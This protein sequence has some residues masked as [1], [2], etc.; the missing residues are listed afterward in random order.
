MKSLHTANF[1]LT[2]E[3]ARNLVNDVENGKEFD[4][5]NLIGGFYANLEDSEIRDMFKGMEVRIDDLDYLLGSE[6]ERKEEERENTNPEYKLTKEW[7][8]SLDEENK[9]MVLRF[10]N[11]RIGDFSPRG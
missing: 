11:A 9:S 10:M 3:G 8:N 7:F 6:E 2:L 1:G 5:E 4:L